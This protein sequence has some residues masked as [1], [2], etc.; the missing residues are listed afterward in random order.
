MHCGYYMLANVD[1]HRTMDTN[2]F[3]GRAKEICINNADCNQL[4]LSDEDPSQAVYWY[5]PS[6]HCPDYQIMNAEIRGCTEPVCQYNQ[7]ITVE[8][9]C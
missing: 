3:I 8:G 6:A 7:Y 9:A 5:C 1:E 2:S 4:R